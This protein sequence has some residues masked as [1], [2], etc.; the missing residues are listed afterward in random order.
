M[1]KLGSIEEHTCLFEVNKNMLVCILYE[2]AC[3]RCF[4]CKVTLA[5][6]KLNK[7]KIVLSADSCV[8]FTECGS[9]MNDT[10]TVCHCNIAV[11]HYKESLFVLFV[12]NGLDEVE[13]RLVFLVLKSLTGE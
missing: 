13:E 7:G 1:L 10:C 12:T 5:V 8:V 4:F 3:V 6:N 11:T 9:T 2:D